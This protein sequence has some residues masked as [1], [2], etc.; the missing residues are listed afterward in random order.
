MVKAIDVHV[1]VPRQPGLPPTRL[2]EAMRRYF[3]AGPP[4]PDADTMA[5]QYK[6]WDIIGV[7]L[8]VDT[9]TTSGEPP[10]S[11]DYVAS[12]VKKYPQQFIG[13]VGIDPWKGKKA[14]EELE[15]GVKQLGLRG[16]KLHPNHQAFFPND[17]R[18]YPLYDAARGLG[19]P[20]LF[21][22]GHAGAGAGL[23]GGG[24]I[25][26]K[27]SNPLHIDDVAADFPDLT[28]IMAHPGWPWQEEQIAV[29]IHKANVYI[30]LSG[31]APRYFP[32][33]LVREISTRL[34]DKVLFGSDYP[35]ITP[36]R[37]LREFEAL[38]IKDEVR[39]K[40][41]LENARRALKLA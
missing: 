2:S 27:Y 38:P 18:F 34:Q 12:I 8:T 30:D 20:V 3:R 17:P 11:I 7:L 5:A 4:P 29:A 39:P 10:D 37:W 33:S 40:V 24:G 25:K 41:L 21:H 36:E 1:H 31:W 22:S 32:D 13:F 28:I 26:L 6:A 35:L 19:I 15:R 9:E 23:P 16:L 14:I